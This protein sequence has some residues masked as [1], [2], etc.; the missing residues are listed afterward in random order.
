MKSTQLLIVAGLIAVTTSAY[1][2][3]DAAQFAPGIEKRY[4]DGKIVVYYNNSF[5]PTCPAQEGGC[6][7]GVLPYTDVE[8]DAEDNVINGRLIT[9]V[10]DTVD[11][12][13]PFPNDKVDLTAEIQLLESR[14]PAAP[15][16]EQEPITDETVDGELFQT[17]A[18]RY[19]GA[20]LSH[21]PGPIAI[22]VL[23]T[24]TD[25]VNSVDVDERLVCNGL[26][27]VDGGFS[28]IDVVRRPKV[29]ILPFDKPYTGQHLRT[30][31]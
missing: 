3:A 31:N 27:F 5:G 9:E 16:L 2:S 30:G 6:L 26:G 17:F 25:G 24:I 10:G 23:G 11:D 8:Y 28:C 14:D 18:F 20:F 4:A 15:I 7:I 1:R 19:R 13:S 29:P 22:T 12:P 21:K